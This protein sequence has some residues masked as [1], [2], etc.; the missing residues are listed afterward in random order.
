M[1]QDTVIA[2][3][4]RPYRENQTLSFL[5]EESACS[6]TAASGTVAQNVPTVGANRNRTELTG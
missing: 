4:S 5:E 3:T 2:F 1:R 6:S